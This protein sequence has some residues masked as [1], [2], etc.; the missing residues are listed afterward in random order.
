MRK[1]GRLMR[2]SRYG[3]CVVFKDEAVATLWGAYEGAVKPDLDPRSNGACYDGSD[4]ALLG[5]DVSTLA[6]CSPP[7]LLSTCVSLKSMR[8]ASGAGN[9]ARCLPTAYPNAK[10]RR[11]LSN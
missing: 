2:Q 4:I 1:S 7:L 9:R 10:H 11:Q 5:K 6:V 8:C 3:P